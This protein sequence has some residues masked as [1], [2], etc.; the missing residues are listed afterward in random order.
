LDQNDKNVI[1]NYID[2]NTNHVSASDESSNQVIKP[3]LYKKESKDNNEINNNVD[4]ITNHNS[5]FDNN[6]N[7]VMQPTVNKICKNKNVIIKSN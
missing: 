2:S 7:Q 3:K 6:S 4:S 1:N 5:N